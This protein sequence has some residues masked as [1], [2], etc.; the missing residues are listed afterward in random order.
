MDGRKE[1]VLDLT[2]FDFAD[3]EVASCPPLTSAAKTTVF[4]RARV[5]FWLSSD[6]LRLK[7]VT[8]SRGIVAI[9][10]AT[11]REGAALCVT[12]AVVTGTAGLAATAGE[13]IARIAGSVLARAMG[14]L[15][16]DGATTLPEPEDMAMAC[17]GGVQ[18]L[19]M[20]TLAPGIEE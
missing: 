17:L 10:L 6:G 20:L 5:G 3:D 12:A 13:D 7:D 8:L 16:S 18:A 19:G 11:A 4:T 14:D 9:A 15:A 2:P 1:T